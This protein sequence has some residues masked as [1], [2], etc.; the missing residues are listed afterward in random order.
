M[1]GGEHSLASAWALAAHRATLIA[2]GHTEGILV[3]VIPGE[4]GGNAEGTSR[5]L[6]LIMHVISGT[7]RLCWLLSYCYYTMTKATCRVHDAR[8]GGKGQREGE[9]ENESI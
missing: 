5:G 4:Q 7:W 9:M 1:R 8:Q 3:R 6:V 2:L